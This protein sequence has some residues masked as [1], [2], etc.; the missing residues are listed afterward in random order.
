MTFP[1]VRGRVCSFGEVNIKMFEETTEEE[2]DRGGSQERAFEFE[3]IVN[4]NATHLHM[5]HFNNHFPFQTVSAA[6]L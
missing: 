6:A 4:F 2:A 5:K 1:F 3:C